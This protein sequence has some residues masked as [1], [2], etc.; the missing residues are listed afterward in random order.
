MSMIKNEKR[1][2]STVIATVMLVL[3][4]VIAVTIIAAVVFNL[5]KP[6]SSV[7][8]FD[9]REALY[10]KNS[11]GTSK[12]CISTNQIDL[13]I[14]RSTDPK[15]DV[16][17]FVVKFEGDSSAKS[18]NV[19]K[20]ETPGYVMIVDSGKTYTDP[21]GIVTPGTEFTYRF[22]DIDV[23]KVVKASVAPVLKGNNAPCEYLDSID[24]P[25]C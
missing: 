20:D 1:G 19:M 2:L 16:V 25:A 8:C 7:S 6:G 21:I 12:T 10:F 13:I 3:L 11:L 5:V 15:I 14:G 9:A 24:I 17:G 18:Y 22:K 4:T 23:T